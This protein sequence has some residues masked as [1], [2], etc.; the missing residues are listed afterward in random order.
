MVLA[1][2]TEVHHKTQLPYP[3]TRAAAVEGLGL[4]ASANFLKDIFLSISRFEFI[5]AAFLLRRGHYGCYWCS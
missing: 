4:T 2:E 5:H 3:R 1:G